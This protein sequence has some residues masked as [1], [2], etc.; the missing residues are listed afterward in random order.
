MLI[1]FWVIE[2]QTKTFSPILINKI[3]FN[4]A[5]FVVLP[6]IG[7]YLNSYMNNWA[8]NE[9]HHWEMQITK[10]KKKSVTDRIEQ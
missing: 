1:H 5:V 6:L 8:S 3:Q 2:I 10:K 4:M 9:N 7:A